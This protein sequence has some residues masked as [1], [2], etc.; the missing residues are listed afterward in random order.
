MWPG[1]VVEFSKGRS[2]RS[3]WPVNWTKKFVKIGGDVEK[4]FFSLTKYQAPA[5]NMTSSAKILVAVK[6]SV[7]LV[8]HLTL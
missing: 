1:D 6:T 2:R 3:V 8:T 4:Q 7:T 5:A